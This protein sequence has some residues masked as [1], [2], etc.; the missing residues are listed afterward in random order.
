MNNKS[1]LFFLPFFLLGLCAAV[2]LLMFLC[3][4]CAGNSEVID[5]I[6]LLKIT[7][8]SCPCLTVFQSSA[9]LPYVLKLV[10]LPFSHT[11]DPKQSGLNPYLDQV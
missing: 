10:V 3:R 4:E 8:N 1:L 5:L 7:L 9:E 2:S 11:P 6:S